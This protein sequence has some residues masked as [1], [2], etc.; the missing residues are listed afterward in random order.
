MTANLPVGIAL[1]TTINVALASPAFAAV[2]DMICHAHRETQVSPIT[3]DG[4]VASKSIWQ[5]F[6]MSLN[7]TRSLFGS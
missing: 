7:A 5:L 6:L 4:A 2:P 1:L 3:L